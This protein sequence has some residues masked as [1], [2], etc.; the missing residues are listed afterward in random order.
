[1]SKGLAE[2]RLRESTDWTCHLRHEESQTPLQGADVS[3]ESAFSWPMC[4]PDLPSADHGLPGWHCHTMQ[5]IHATPY[6]S[7]EF[8]LTVC[9]AIHRLISHKVLAAAYRKGH[10]IIM[11]LQGACCAHTLTCFLHLGFATKCLQS[12]TYDLLVVESQRW[13]FSDREPVGCCCII[14]R[15]T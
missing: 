15:T 1:M 4:Q 9:Y 11:S 3:L 8:L 13:Q 10:A 6:A 5:H 2:H 14:L 7:D 12:F